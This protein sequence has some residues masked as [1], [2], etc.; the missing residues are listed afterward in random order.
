MRIKTIRFSPFPSRFS[1]L[2]KNLR[3]QRYALINAYGIEVSDPAN[4]FERSVYLLPRANAEA[5]LADIEAINARLEELQ[6]EV[7]QFIGTAAFAK[8]IGILESAG[9]RV[10]LPAFRIGRVSVRLTP[11]AS[12]RNSSKNSRKPA[13]RSPRP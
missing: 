4:P 8:V 7:D 3:K 1:N 12:R 9:L 2:L 5:F 6:R 10:K 11:A 13:R